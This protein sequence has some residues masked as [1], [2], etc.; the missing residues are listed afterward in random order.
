MNF[1]WWYD[2]YQI[3]LLNFLSSSPLL[4]YF[5]DLR[6]FYYSSVNTKSTIVLGT[7]RASRPYG[8]VWLHISEPT[9]L[10]PWLW[11]D[12][13]RSSSPPWI[14]FRQLLVLPVP[15]GFVAGRAGGGS[16]R[17]YH[18]WACSWLKQ[19]RVCVRTLLSLDHRL[20]NGCI[21]SRQSVDPLYH[22]KNTSLAI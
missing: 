4:E 3:N 21:A 13:W 18:F 20:C 2:K 22:I 10:V 15:P 8:R 7:E 12:L 5:G 14:N 17:S 1:P 16:A 19:V 6:A 11:V 9:G